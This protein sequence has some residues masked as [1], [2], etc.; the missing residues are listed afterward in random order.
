ME[1]SEPKLTGTLWATPRLLR[2][3][4]TL[5]IDRLL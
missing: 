3:S 1:I 4:F 2:D 5:L